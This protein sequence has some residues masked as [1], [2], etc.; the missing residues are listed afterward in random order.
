MDKKRNPEEFYQSLKAQLE[1]GFVWP[2]LYLYKFIIPASDEQIAEIENIFDNEQAK[3]SLK[4]SSKGK[5]VSVSI[6]VMM[7]SPDHV[8][9]KYREIGRR[10]PEVI[11]L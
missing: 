3:I 5:Y 7:Q 4:E 10:I 6:R 8:I 1:D 2:H 9:E 11:S